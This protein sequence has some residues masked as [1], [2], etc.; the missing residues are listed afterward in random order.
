M[1]AARLNFDL[2]WR[3][4]LAMRV[5]I[6]KRNETGRR[7]ALVSHHTELMNASSSGVKLDAGRWAWS[8]AKETA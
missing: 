4:H 1:G 8:V 7:R 2:A 5:P 6:E 3:V